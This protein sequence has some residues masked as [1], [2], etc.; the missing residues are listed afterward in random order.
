MSRARR[1][2]A[3]AARAGRWLWAENLALV[4]AAAAAG[5][6]ELVLVRAVYLAAFGDERRIPPSADLP[7]GHAVLWATGL[8]GGGLACA[9]AYRLLRYG[10]PW[11]AGLLVGAVCFPLLVLALAS[12]YGS[13]LV[14]S[15]L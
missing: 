1:A 5:A 7:L 8:A 14:S 2:L 12:L 6:A 15:L 11:S 9:A 13:L 4:L 3:M 10:R